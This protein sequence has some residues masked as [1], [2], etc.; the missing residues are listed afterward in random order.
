MIKACKAAREHGA[1]SLPFPHFKL[2]YHVNRS[3]Y[4]IS[5]IIL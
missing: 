2:G 4:A 1:F 3:I 5:N